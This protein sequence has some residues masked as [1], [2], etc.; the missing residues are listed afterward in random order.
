MLPMID[1]NAAPE[2]IVV[3]SIEEISNVFFDQHKDMIDQLLDREV[4]ECMFDMGIPYNTFMTM[5]THA[6]DLTEEQ[7]VDAF[8]E[9]TTT[10]IFID[11]MP[12]RDVFCIEDVLIVADPYGEI[13][14][15]F[16]VENFVDV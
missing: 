6:Y 2:D 14:V 15:K 7:V 3:D 13:N 1:K 8:N 9:I 12:G 5:V 4:S 11:K 16:N 10:P